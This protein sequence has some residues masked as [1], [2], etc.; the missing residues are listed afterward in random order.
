[1]P[2]CITDSAYISAANRQAAAIRTQAATDVAIQTAVALWQRNA[3]QSISNMQTN[4]ANQ[5]VVLAEQVHAHAVLFW[6]EETELVNDVFSETRITAPYTALGSAWGGIAADTMQ[7]ARQVWIDTQRANCMSPSRCDDARWQR[8]AGAARVDLASYGYRQ[9][10]AR[11]QITNDRRYARQLAVLG[12]GRGRTSTLISYQSVSQFSGL[13]A[14]SML[15]AG[16][17]SALTVY[18]YESE[19]RRQPTGWA[20]GI[21]QTWQAR[22]PAPVR[23]DPPAAWNGQPLPG[24]VPLAPIAAPRAAPRTGKEAEFDDVDWGGL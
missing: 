13:S 9:A 19:M 23:P 14:G 8:H 7:Q 3:S 11:E 15:E 5:Q 12:L 22:M 17:N 10:E 24:A 21:Q 1:M 4:L 2:N 6:P 18:G 16:I 20:A